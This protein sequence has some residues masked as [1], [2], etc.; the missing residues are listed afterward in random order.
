MDFTF[1]SIKQ[2]LVSKLKEYSEWSV[3]ILTIGV[4]SV[5]LDIVAFI[6]EKLAFYVDFLFIET[7]SNAV[8]RS[9]VVRIAKDHGYI[10]NRKSGA[11]G[12]LVIGDDETFNTSYK[13]YQGKMILINKWFEFNSTDGQS[14][15]YCQNDVVYNEGSIQ[16]TLY[17]IPGTQSLSLENGFET[18]IIITGHGLQAGDIVFVS[19]T[20]NLNGVWL[21]TANTTANRL[22]ILRDYV[23]ETFTGLEQVRS[24]YMFVNVREGKP[25]QY[26]YI[27][28]GDINEKIPIYSDSIDQY[29]IEV[30]LINTSGDILQIVEIVDD[31]YFVNDISKYT[32]MIENFS[33]YGGIWIKF[34]DNITSRRTIEDERYLIKYAI[35]KG[36]SGNITQ[37]GTITESITPFINVYREVETLYIT[38]IQPIIDGQDLETL[39]QIKKAYSQLYATGKQ[40][41]R[42][43]AW[44][45]AVESAQF[46]YKAIV[47]TALDIG[48]GSIPL[49]LTN[50]QNIHY[51]TA[52]N[53]EGYALTPVQENDISLSI[54]IPRKSP[55]DV[56]SWQKLNKIRIKLNSL[57]EITRTITFADMEI[58]LNSYLKSK[59]GVLNLDFNKNLYAS[60]VIKYIDEF[61]NV[62]RH[63][64]E[65]FYA[66]ENIDTSFALYDFSAS[67]TGDIVKEEDKIIVLED[68]PQIWIRRKVNGVWYPPLQISETNGITMSGV[69]L[70]DVRG[71]VIY[72]NINTSQI[73]YQC[74]D[75]LN[76]INPYFAAT[77]TTENE[78][79]TISMVDLSGI[80]IGMYVSGIN[81][82]DTSKIINIDTNSNSI[83]LDKKTSS[84]DNGTGQILVSWFPD[85]GGIFGARNPDDSQPYGYVLYLV[86][87]TRDGNGDRIGD[88]RLADFNQILDYSSDLSK[89]EFIYE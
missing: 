69:N 35:T 63:E 25:K 23:E 1:S 5:L 74:F 28:N 85:M 86:Y 30:Y 33:D 32:C 51:I 39:Y 89:F 47:W 10:P 88:L 22:A 71:T 29:N 42:R 60:N 48:K 7:T 68:T 59:I 79:Q 37:Y 44:T 13:Q 34:G 50:K 49:I 27:A 15:V 83:I 24:G 3:E 80:N 6:I 12:Y 84:Q 73:T 54:L 43:G 55:T 53:S 11:T 4:Y 58:N 52:V 78:S 14:L 82:S 81:I 8:L 64:T 62:I 75:L 16:K 31:I 72:E 87:Q 17:P 38:N 2:S 77:G 18:G 66:E 56:I 21:L 9:S 26:T 36:S 40:L 46:V 76:N 19:G 67:Y 41:T 45:T 57:I 61:S 65:I 70:Y 20:Q